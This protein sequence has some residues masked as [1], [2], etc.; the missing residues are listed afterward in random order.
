[1]KNRNS[2]SETMNNFP[3]ESSQFHSFQADRMFVWHNESY[4]LVLYREIAFL[5][6]SS[7]YSFIHFRDGKK[8]LV[9]YPMKNVLE[10]LP[11]TQFLRISR[12]FTVNLDCVT[13]FLGNMVYIGERDFL[14]SPAYRETLWSCFTFLKR[15][16]A[17][18]K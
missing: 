15:M 3:A 9:V 18:H 8:W 17:L 13:R 14:I 2:I 6:A 12:S 10:H 7:D 11:S 1:M 4:Q 16:R 5:E